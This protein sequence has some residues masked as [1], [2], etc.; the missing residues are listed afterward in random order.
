MRLLLITY[1]FS[2]VAFGF[3]QEKDSLYNKG[4]EALS[5]KNYKSAQEYFIQ[6]VEISPSFEGYYNLGFAY[7]EQKKWIESL[8]ANE[9]ALK[10]DP[11]NSKAIY[12]AKFS[13][14][15]ISPDADWIHPYSWTTRIILS[16]GETTWFIL[17]L[18]SSLIVAVS[19][20]FLVTQKR[21]NSKSLWSKRLI[22]PFVIILVIS[23]F[24]FNETMNHYQK[25]RY[26]YALVK[27][28]T[29]YL[30]PEGL[31]VDENLPKS[32]RLIVVQNQD[33]WAQV[34]TPDSRT[35]WVKKEDLWIY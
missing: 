23:V 17:M 6:N 19:I 35:F 2:V 3:A 32:K 33:D 11:T 13:L 22:I 28:T 25:I 21:G 9:A 20:Y 14:E 16:A 18:V 15:K 29:V 7:A 24:C 27:E 10:Y 12:N 8:R 30:S 34:F 1:F 5:K 4:L 26:A 31:E